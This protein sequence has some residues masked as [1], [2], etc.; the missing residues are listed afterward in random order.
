MIWVL[1]FITI[2]TGYLLFFSF[3]KCRRT[4]W[5]PF[6]GSHFSPEHCDLR[7][8]D[9]GQ[10]SNCRTF[11]PGHGPQKFVQ[12]KALHIQRKLES[13]V[14]PSDQD[15]FCSSQLSDGQDNV[16]VGAVNAHYMAWKPDL[17][18]SLRRPERVHRSACLVKISICV[19]DDDLVRIVDVY[20]TLDL[21]AELNFFKFFNVPRRTD[22]KST[23]CPGVGH[24]VEH[25]CLWVE[26]RIKNTSVVVRVPV[27]GDVNSK[28]CH[29]MCEFLAF[30]PVDQEI[31]SGNDDEFSVLTVTRSDSL[32]QDLGDVVFDRDNG[33]DHHD[34]VH[35]VV[36]PKQNDV[37][38][39]MFSFKFHFLS[40]MFKLCFF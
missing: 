26:T 15:N 7:T 18:K 34:S 16:T 31:L 12:T 27:L 3:G 23:H 33:L 36:Y 25:G 1:I 11:L 20:D 5:S 13:P 28:K 17:R 32:P 10:N 4:L 6:S 14:L 2:L 19:A 37:I 9:A 30:E 8:N 22:L 40:L 38:W 39:G 29:I 24:K 21:S 35:L